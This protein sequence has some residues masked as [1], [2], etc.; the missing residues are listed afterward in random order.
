M[1]SSGSGG[2]GRDLHASSRG[3]RRRSVS[4]RSAVPNCIRR[5]PKRR[6]VPAKW[7]R[8][9]AREVLPG[10]RA[11]DKEEA[12]NMEGEADRQDERLEVG[13]PESLHIFV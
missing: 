1:I 5:V 8:A 6:H 7:V 4:F 9:D 10:C 13:L 11:D 12:P 2:A 3:R